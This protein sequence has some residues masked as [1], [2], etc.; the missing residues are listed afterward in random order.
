MRVPRY[1]SAARL[2]EILRD[3][4]GCTP[5]GERELYC[6]YWI[7]PDG[8]RFRVLDPIIDP[9]GSYTVS[10]DGRW[11]RVYSIDYARRLLAYLLARMPAHPEPPRVPHL[12][13]DAPSLPPYRRL[14]MKV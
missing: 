4:L 14:D 10:R 8:R 13:I 11:Q 9:S 3:R 6:S 12:E 5:T 2:N 1:I 7:A